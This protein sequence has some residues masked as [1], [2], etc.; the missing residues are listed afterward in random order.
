MDKKKRKDDGDYE[1]KE[2]S[3]GKKHLQLKL[4]QS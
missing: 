3:T 1:L 2:V 4:V